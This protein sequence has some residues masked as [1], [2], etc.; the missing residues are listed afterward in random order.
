MSVTATIFNI[1]RCSLHDGP[2]V[3]TVVYFKGCNLSCAWCHN[4]EGLLVN[5]QISFNKIKCI[6]CGTCAVICPECHTEKGF[7]RTACKACGKCANACTAKALEIVGTKY[8]VADLLAE[9]KKDQAYFERGGGVTVSGGECLLQADFVCEF[10]CQC[11]K[12]KIHTLVESAFCVNRESIEKVLPYTDEFYVDCKIFDSEKHHL[13]TGKHNEQI[14]DNIKFFAP[15]T[16]MTI[17]VPLVPNVSDDIEN[18]KN[19][20]L[21]AK[22]VGAKSVELLRF[23]PLGVSKYESLGKK[24]VV[25]GQTQEKSLVKTLISELNKIVC[26]ENY[27]YCVL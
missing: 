14:L 3:R 1:S 7:N 9:I 17:R 2:G 22:E 23:N 11:K 13:Y 21:F 24:G 19:T 5:S 6:G 12:E 25:F 20:V 26:S 27:V 16:N 15:Q 4:P 18:L 8:N 10:L